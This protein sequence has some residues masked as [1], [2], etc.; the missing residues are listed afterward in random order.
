MYL[1]LK[2]E[3][4]AEDVFQNFRAKRMKVCT[5]NVK[6]ENS[7]LQAGSESMLSISL[8]HAQWTNKK[9]LVDPRKL[10]RWA[11]VL[12]EKPFKYFK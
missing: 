8:F 3:R 5:K 4:I 1:Y 2:S 6:Q 7:M 10:C 11:S 12:L 9:L